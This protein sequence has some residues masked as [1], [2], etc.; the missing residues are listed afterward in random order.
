MTPIS[1][2]LLAAG[3][4]PHSQGTDRERLAQAA[5][6]FEAIF[7]RQVLAEARKSHFGG[8]MFGEGNPDSA[9]GTFRKMQD[10]RVADLAAERGAFGIAKQIEASLQSQLAFSSPS[11]LREGS[12]ERLLPTVSQ[13]ALPQ[14]LPR[15][16]GEI[17]APSPSARKD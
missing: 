10:E 7:V 11:R 15:A 16:G 2:P 3:S 1:S 13:H 17:K 5:R 6:Q 8:D 9:L 14:P 12:G 4:L